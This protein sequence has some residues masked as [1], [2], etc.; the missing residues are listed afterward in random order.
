VPACHAGGRGFES[1]RS[2]GLHATCIAKALEASSKARLKSRRRR[3]QRYRQG[4]AIVIS[5]LRVAL[6]LLA[7]ATAALVSA[8]ALVASS[9]A[10]RWLTWNVATETASLTLVAGYN[11][12]NNG[13]NFDG[14]GRGKLLVRMPLGWR[15][16]VTCHNAASMRHS[17]AIVRGP[18]SVTPAFRGAATPSPTVGLRS[19]ETARFS[20][21]AA[22]AGSYRIACLAPGHEQ[23]RMWDVLVVGGVRRPSISARTGF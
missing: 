10:G 9:P 5:V 20:F 6:A 7:T 1:R 3:W 14:F 21:K 22:R 8:S 19:G 17:C 15:V 11:S 12:A 16:L 13:F 23:A 2:R 18:L 4:Y